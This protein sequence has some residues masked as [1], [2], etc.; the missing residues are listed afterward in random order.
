[1]LTGYRPRQTMVP[2]TYGL[3][4]L[5]QLQ[6]PGGPVF[7]GEKTPAWS[8]SA[9]PR[10]QLTTDKKRGHAFLFGGVHLQLLCRFIENAALR[11]TGLCFFA[12]G[13]QFFRTL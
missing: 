4:R 6:Q 11:P 10:M 12:K 7:V 3:P 8:G 9:W 5:N 1:M 2:D 13:F